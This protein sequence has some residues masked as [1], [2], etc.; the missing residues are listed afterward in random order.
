MLINCPEC[1]EQVSDEAFKCP[2]CGKRLKY[3]KRG[4]MG[5]L[6]LWAF[7]IYN[8]F[9]AFATYLGCRASSEMQEQFTDE[10]SRIGGAA[11]SVIG[12]SIVLGIWMAGAIIIGIFVLLT[13]PK[14]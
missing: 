3:P 12:S 1:N 11:G 6:F 9:M 10:A 8:A 7:Y 2:K 4:C 5:Q 13:R 14:E